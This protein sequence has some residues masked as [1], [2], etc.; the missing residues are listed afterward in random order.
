MDIGIE[1][2]NITKSFSYSDGGTKNAI[3]RLFSRNKKVIKAVDEVSFSV[4]PGETV[5]FIG[6][7]GAGKST[8]IKMMTGILHPTEGSISVLGLDPTSD[9]KKLAF[10]IGTVFGQRSQLMF[11]LPVSDSFELFSKIYEI[12]N[13][14]SR[15]KIKELFELFELSEYADQP[16]RKLSL[17]QRMRAEVA[18]SLLHSPRILFLDEPTIGLD[19]VAKKKLRDILSSLNKKEGVTIFLTSHDVGDIESLT[20]R[21]I[22]I[23][24]GRVLVDEK[25]ENLKKKYLSDKRVKVVSSDHIEDINIPGVSILNNDANMTFLSINTTKISTSDVLKELVS[26]YNVLDVTVED[27]PL[28]DIISHLYQMKHTDH[29]N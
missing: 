9:R 26:L 6:P 14:I 19:I 13:D 1:V 24:H 28:E 10:S 29:D 11:N 15:R 12:P 22:L 3:K 20:E 8:M 18:L 5:A 2:K 16:V 7:N 17:G 21:T 4:R 25:T 27:P 23:N